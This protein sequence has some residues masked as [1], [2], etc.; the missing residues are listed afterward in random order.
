[1][2]KQVARAFGQDELAGRAGTRV[3]RMDTRPEGKVRAGCANAPV[4]ALALRHGTGRS[5][6]ASAGVGSSA[7]NIAG[8]GQSN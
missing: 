6:R 7:S 1:M 8:A 3:R 4:G 5:A 2:H